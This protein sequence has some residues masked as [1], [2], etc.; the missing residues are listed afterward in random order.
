[1]RALRE[2]PPVTITQAFHACLTPS[3]S[4]IECGLTLSSSTQQLRP[5]TDAA[6]MKRKGRIVRRTALITG[7]SSGIGAQFARHLAPDHDLLPAARSDDRPTALQSPPARVHPDGVFRIQVADLATP[8]VVQTLI[9]RVRDDA[10][11]VDLLINNAGVGSHGA[12]TTEDPAAMLAQIQLNCVCLV[13]LTRA[14]LPAMMD[15]G[16]GAVINV[17][18]PAAFQPTP[19]P[20]PPWRSPRPRSPPPCPSARP[21][22]WKPAA[23]GSTCWPYAPARPRPASSPQPAATSSPP[24]GKRRARSSPQAC[25]RYAAAGR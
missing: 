7:A 12:F 16:H 24:A 21:P 3:S 11:V 10:I 1:S 14:L 4:L 22:R 8:A 2:L 23:R 15:R 18:S 9:D 13:S 25:T 6:A 19:S 20:P 5:A 17:A